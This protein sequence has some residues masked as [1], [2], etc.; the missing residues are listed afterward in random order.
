MMSSKNSPPYAKIIEKR[1]VVNI[2]RLGV[3][4]DTSNK[5]FMGLMSIDEG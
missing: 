3:E 1:L 2:E 5:Y 4:N